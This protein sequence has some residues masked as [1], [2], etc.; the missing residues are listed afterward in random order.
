MVTPDEIRQ[1]SFSIARRGFDQVEVSSYLLE[2]AKSV[3]GVLN[4]L[5]AA[6]A[7]AAN[8]SNA[9]PT[10]PSPINH[11]DDFDKVASEMS[12]LLRSAHEKAVKLRSDAENE[13]RITLERVE[14]EIGDK[15]QQHED[16][17]ANELSHVEERAQRI[18]DEADAYAAETR[19]AAD[20]YGDA[21]RQ[22]AR[23][24]AS[25]M[26]SESEKFAAAAREEA[27]TMAD[28]IRDQVLDET[29]AIR[30]AAAEQRDEAECLHRTAEESAAT[31]L[32][33][34]ERRA[35][36]IIEGA[37]ELAT[38]RVE[39]TLTE[40]R[41]AVRAL[42]EAEHVARENITAAHRALERVMA[43]IEAPDLEIESFEVDD[44]PDRPVLQS[45]SAID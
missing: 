11:V 15:R 35:K 17:M 29:A 16:E 41:T 43:D 20:S 3:D 25:R 12:G 40:G 26:M 30:M 39:E 24:E 14:A 2:V 7:V 4:D 45:V 9:A 34:A 18:K 38:A 5:E 31:S 1:K 42:L 28:T 44:M 8:K 32:E 23:K 21:L 22:E 27:T 13:A 37:K 6:R 36:D 33:D 10:T 19:E